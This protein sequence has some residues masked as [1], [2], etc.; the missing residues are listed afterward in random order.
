VQAKAG[1]AGK[2]ASKS[3]AQKNV[4]A[5]LV[6]HALNS[7]SRITAAMVDACHHLGATLA[8]RD[9]LQ[10]LFRYLPGPSNSLSINVAAIRNLEAISH[11]RRMPPAFSRVRVII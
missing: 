3:A 8:L 9:F 5:P 11:R 10:T 6:R 1:A 2:V 4:Q 7:F